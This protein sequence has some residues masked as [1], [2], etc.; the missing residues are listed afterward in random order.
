MLLLVFLQ[1]PKKYECR[2]LHTVLATFFVCLQLPTSALRSLDLGFFSLLEWESAALNRENS[3]A[4]LRGS[5]TPPPTHDRSPKS[6][7]YENMHHGIAPRV[8]QL[9]RDFQIFG[10]CASKGNGSHDDNP[11]SLGQ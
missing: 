1:N 2:R 11:S 6:Y 5:E 3:R 7:V 9:A 10:A 4:I 8:G